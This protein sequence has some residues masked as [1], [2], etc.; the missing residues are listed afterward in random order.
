M[1]DLIYESAG[2]ICCSI[3]GGQFPADD[4]GSRDCLFPLPLF[5]LDYVYK[6]SCNLTIIER[7]PIEKPREGSFDQKARKK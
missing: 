1:S 2:K 4:A 5:A 7:T 3:L 6:F